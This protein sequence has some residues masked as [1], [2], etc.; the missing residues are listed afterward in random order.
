MICER[1]KDTGLIGDIPAAS[2]TAQGWNG[3]CHVFG[4]CDCQIGHDKKDE[5][6]GLTPL[7]R[8]DPR[9]FDDVSITLPVEF[10]DD[11]ST[12]RGRAGGSATN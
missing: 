3:R 9:L 8:F 4:F 7:R 6:F 10:I 2:G 11:E 5:L 1:C 12:E